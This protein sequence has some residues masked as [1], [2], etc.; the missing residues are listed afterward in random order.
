MPTTDDETLLRGA[1]PT[2]LKGRGTASA[3][4]GR[5]AKLIAVRDVTDTDEEGENTPSPVTELRR[6]TARSLITRNDSPDVPF[7]QSVNPYRGCE[8]GCIYCFAR[9]THAYLDLSP[10]IDFET[11]LS[12]KHNA[13]EL[14]ERELRHPRYRCE[15]IAL[16]INTDAYQPVEKEQGIVRRLLRIA[17][18]YRQ[19]LSLITKSGLILRD[20]DLLAAMAE[21]N[22]VHVGVSVT[23]LDNDLKRILEPR[24]AAPATRLKV[25]RQL[26]DAG[27]PVSA[28]VAPVI[29]LINDAELE[30]IVHACAEAGAVAAGYVLLR[31]PHEVAP[32]FVEWLQ[33]HFPDR[34]EHVL[35]TLRAMR[36]GKL[37]DSRFGERM[38]GRG[39]YADLIRQRFR[40]ARRRSGL[41]RRDASG[42]DCSQFAPPP[43]AGDQGCLPF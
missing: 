15:P 26:S 7:T 23:T 16:G 11:R 30:S 37:Y 18:D 42:L 9:P 19:P 8:H 32:L 1:P 40:L 34:A 21:R 14:F 39:L 2:V 12:V 25:I 22:L 38:R 35:N 10:G 5:F 20:L 13:P 43:R 36:G 24:T 6:E 29:P 41:E 17:L 33:L 28:M 3:L 4:P 31:L 27:V